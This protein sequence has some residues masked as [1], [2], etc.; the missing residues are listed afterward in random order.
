MKTALKSILSVGREAVLLVVAETV[1]LAAFILI[2][3]EYL[4]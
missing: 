3:I 4:G 1:F 2:G